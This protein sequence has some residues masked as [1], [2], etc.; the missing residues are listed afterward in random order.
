[1]KLK[2]ELEGYLVEKAFEL[3]DLNK[4]ATEFAL[5]PNFDET[6]NTILKYYSLKSELSEF[7][8]DLPVSKINNPQARELLRKIFSP[9]GLHIERMSKAILE[10]LQINS[11]PEIYFS[12]KDYRKLQELASDH[13]YSW[14]GPYEYVERLLKIGFVILGISVPD[15]FHKFVDQARQCY[16]FQQ[17]LA[18]Y[19]LCR[20]IL[21]I[22]VR[23]VGQKKGK[24]PHDKGKV[25]EDI[26]RRF[27]DM[28]NK[29]VPT[30]Q[31]DEIGKIYDKAS[32]LIHGNKIVGES[33]A[34]E[35]FERTL[36]AVYALYH[37]YGYA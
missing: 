36:K 1:M 35:L 5:E 6:I 16:A 10:I 14:F 28:K 32:G 24:L 34:V 15:S 31:K 25:K 19:S 9:D 22:A 4:K 8:I 27:G 20:T 12:D 3:G 11:Q 29:I 18:V 7:F 37:Y 17:Y 2:A 30:F 33:E 21:E 26:L 23:D 13:L